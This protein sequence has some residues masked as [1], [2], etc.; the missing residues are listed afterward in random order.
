MKASQIFSCAMIVLYVMMFAGCNKKERLEENPSSNI[1]EPTTL[2]D[3]QT[4][5]DND[6]VFNITPCMGEASADNY[7]LPYA[8]W[9]TLEQKAQRVYTWLPDIFMGIGSEEDWNKPYKQIFYANVVLQG[10]KKISKSADNQKQ[11]DTIQGAALFLRGNA[12]F[13]LSQLFALPYNEQTAASDLGLPLRLNANILEASVRSSVKQTYDQIIADLTAAKDLLPASADT[14]HLNRPT[15]PAAMA[16]LAKV[17]LSMGNYD[18]A[19][20]YANDCLSLHNQLLDYNT[21]SSTNPFPF[22]TSN[23]EILFYSQ[24]TTNNMLMAMVSR[25]TIIDSSLYNSYEVNDLRRTLFYTTNS[26]N[27]PIIKSSYTGKILLFSG[28]ATDEILLIRAECLARSGNK[29]AALKDLNTLLKNRWKKNTFF[30]V[31][32][33]MAIDILQLILQERR[34]ELSFRNVRWTDL[35]RLNKEGRNIQLKRKINGNE[36]ELQPNSIRYVLPIPPDVIAQSNMQ[37]NPR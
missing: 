5:L 2:T 14:G 11:W 17:Y 3:F 4:L 34:K 31:T 15:R 27:K 30:Q 22:K 6:L 20:A 23:P 32:D 18:S 13:E 19:G 25:G 10:M 24:S 36:Y 7:Y 33:N 16:L 9:Q 29:T 1:K 37:Q 26:D 8:T 12:F 35:R 21:I 28:L